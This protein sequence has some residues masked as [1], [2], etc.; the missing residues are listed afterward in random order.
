MYMHGNQKQNVPYELKIYELI[1][2]TNNLPLCKQLWPQ[3]I[4][5]N[6]QYFCIKLIQQGSK[7]HPV[8]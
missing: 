4:V 7:K 1:T 8:Q 5:H 6:V 2:I 3:S